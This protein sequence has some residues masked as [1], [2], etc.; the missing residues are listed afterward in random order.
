MHGAF[1]R[2]TGE[3]LSMREKAVLFLQ[4]WE[5][6]EAASP[7]V[8]VPSPRLQSLN[9]GWSLSWAGV[10]VDHWGRQAGLKVEGLV[11]N[12]KEFTLDFVGCS[13]QPLLM[14]RIDGATVNIPMIPKHLPR[15]FQ[16][17]RPGVEFEYLT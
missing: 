4:G 7:R 15:G 14:T 3:P 1:I 13:S 2:P 6:E 8:G 5:R 11:L 17:I 16:S 12:V 9:W 10:A